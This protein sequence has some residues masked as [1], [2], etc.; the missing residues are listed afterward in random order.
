[1]IPV[2]SLPPNVLQMLSR[3]SFK[4]F[5]LVFTFLPRSNTRRCHIHLLPF[6]P[7]M[8]L[9]C[10]EEVPQVVVLSISTTDRGVRCQV[11]GVGGKRQSCVASRSARV[12]VQLQ[13]QPCP[14]VAKCESQSGRRQRGERVHNLPL[15]TAAAAV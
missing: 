15:I 9:R 10:F 6:R 1:M 8:F 14:L 3:C 13:V 5:D 2:P 11:W 4:V 12:Q 7:L